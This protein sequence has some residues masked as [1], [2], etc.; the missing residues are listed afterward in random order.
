LILAST[1]GY[2]NSFKTDADFLQ[3]GQ[4]YLDLLRRGGIA[5]VAHELPA[6]LEEASKLGSGD[7]I[8]LCLAV[9]DPAAPD[10]EGCTGGL[11]KRVTALETK[12]R[13][14]DNTVRTARGRHALA[15]ACSL[16]ALVTALYVL[17][18]S[19]HSENPASRP[20]G[21]GPSVE[22]PGHP[23]PDARRPGDTPEGASRRQGSPYQPVAPVD[24]V[25]R[26]LPSAPDARP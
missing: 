16:V 19:R 11:A 21:G 25:R 12:M 7:D 20:I 8:T 4:D 23:G 18:T 24:T 2:A 15:L 26:Q 1:D 22:Q 6:F 10:G 13:H 3:I 17:W 14:L 9:R 5:R